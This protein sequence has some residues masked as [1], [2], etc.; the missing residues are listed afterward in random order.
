MEYHFWQDGP[1]HD[2]NVNEPKIIHEQIDYS[3]NNPVKK[4]LVEKAE[5]W[6]W[7]SAQAWAG[8]PN[9]ILKID[10][11]SVPSLVN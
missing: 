3:H 11:D 7:S 1:G 6:R 2:R 10:R 9:P 4:G 8:D 5:D